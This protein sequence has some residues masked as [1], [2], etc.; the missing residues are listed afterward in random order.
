MYTFGLHLGLRVG[1]I[2]QKRTN[3][4]HSVEIAALEVV[5]EWWDSCIETHSEKV[6]IIANCVE[7]IGKANLV[8]VVMEKLQPE[9]SDGQHA[10]STQTN[11]YNNERE[12]NDNNDNGSQSLQQSPE[13]SNVQHANST[14]TNGNDNNDESNDGSE[15]WEQWSAQRNVA[16][17]Q[18]NIKQ[19]NGGFQNGNNLKEFS[20]HAAFVPNIKRKFNEENT[21]TK[22]KYGRLSGCSE[23]QT[24]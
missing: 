21:K 3:N 4:P 13:P 20:C 6:K 12:L 1:Q 17:E 19:V 16:D 9:R 10:N 7:K 11:G 14:Q 24:I 22:S 2:K 8:S 5:T 18:T 23:E 15:N